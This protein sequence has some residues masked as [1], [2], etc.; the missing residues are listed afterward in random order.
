MGGRR[1]LLNISMKKK[2]YM[3]ER[4]LISKHKK[5]NTDGYNF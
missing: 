1:N 4:D 2:V 3:M 5:I